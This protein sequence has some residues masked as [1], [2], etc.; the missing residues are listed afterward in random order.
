MIVIIFSKM[1]LSQ[2]DNIFIPANIN[3]FVMLFEVEREQ[4]RNKM[5]E[6][7]IFAWSKPKQPVQSRANTAFTV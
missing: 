5:R 6:S 2:S 4:Q 3:F 1:I 7:R